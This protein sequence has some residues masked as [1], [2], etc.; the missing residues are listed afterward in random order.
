VKRKDRDLILVTILV[1][2]LF[3]ALTSGLWFQLGWYSLLIMLP[4]A[5]ALEFVLLG[6]ID[7][8]YIIAEKQRLIQLGIM[9]SGETQMVSVEEKDEID[10]LR[11]FVRLNLSDLNELLL[12]LE[13]GY[14][15]ALE[16][17]DAGEI[18]D[19]KFQFK[20]ISEATLKK[21]QDLSDE[22]EEIFNEFPTLED[23]EKNFLY[24]SY[25]DHWNAEK[26]QKEKNMNEIIQKFKVRTIF[27]VHLE[28]ILQ[29][30][31]ENERPITDQ[32]IKRM[33]YPYTQAKQLI[34]YIE[35]PISFKMETLSPS[36]RQKYGNLGRKI[37]EI[38]AKNQVTPNLPYLVIKLGVQIQE[39]KR[40]LT[41]LHL[42]RMIDQVYYH[43]KK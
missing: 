16:K 8:K 40:I 41:Y 5:I 26:K 3:S 19:A 33:R 23:K 42:V 1:S 2:V 9:T 4:I 17:L 11:S 24:T 39:S 29:T 10:Q 15:E 27:T 7:K 35:K 32:D 18:E 36:E 25:R 37:I 38:C 43:Y 6:R 34:K 21:L 30:E 14:R 13:E 22:V 28:D 31:V 20:S 12:T